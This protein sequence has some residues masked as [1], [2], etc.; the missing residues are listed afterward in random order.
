MHGIRCCHSF[1][2]ALVGAV[3]RPLISNSSCLLYHVLHKSGMDAM[4]VN[5]CYTHKLICLLRVHSQAWIEL[6]CHHYRNSICVCGHLGIARSIL[7]SPDGYV[8]FNWA[9]FDHQTR[10][11]CFKLVH[12]SSMIPHGILGTNQCDHYLCKIS[13]LF[14]VYK[15]RLTFPGIHTITSL[16]NILCN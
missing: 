5:Y 13:Q 1:A 15:M 2:K 14:T 9:S 4:P 10:D 3:S 12:K 11:W 6:G 16:H 7:E 8:S